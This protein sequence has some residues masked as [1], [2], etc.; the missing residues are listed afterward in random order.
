MTPEQ[1]VLADLLDQLDRIA[2]GIVDDRVMLGEAPR[3][4]AAFE[5]MPPMARTASKALLKGFEQYVDTL[6]R[7][8]RAQL[9]ATGFRLKGLT[10]L[11]VAHKAHELDQV[12]DAG[13]LL[14]LIK[15]RNELTHE[16]PDDAETRY[17]RFSQALNGLLFLDDA[18]AR[19]REFAQTR[20]GEADL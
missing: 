19:V 18:A 11:D 3:T 14:A 4:L 20:M 2:Q 12:S 17:A 1:E 8:I 10:P 15:L 7:V 9:R 16:Y 5:A 6:Q 13:T